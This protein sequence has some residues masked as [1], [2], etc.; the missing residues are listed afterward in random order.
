[1]LLVSSQPVLEF[2]VKN[3]DQ[4]GTNGSVDIGQV[5]LEETT[6]TFLSV[7]LFEAIDSAA[8]FFG[9]ST[10]LHHKSSS[11]GV[12]GVGQGFG[13]GDTELG[14]EELGEHVSLSLIFTE[15]PSLTGIV[16]T[17]VEG[18]V[19]EDTNKGDAQTSVNTLETVG[20]VGFGDTVDKT[21]VLFT[22][23]V[24]QS[25]SAVIEGVH[26]H[27]G[28]STSHTTSEQVTSEEF[29][30]LLFG[31]D[32]GDETSGIEILG[33]EVNGG[34]GEISDDVGQIT[35]PQRDGT[36]FSDAS[37]ET[38]TNTCVGSCLQFSDGVLT[39]HQKLDSFDGGTN[40]LGD[41]T[42]NTT[43]QQILHELVASLLLT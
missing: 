34:G 27:H 32:A 24:G 5:T 22:D 12:E 6:G 2:V 36:F 16:S 8:I 1:M 14:K 9:T 29:E 25:G 7:N 40:G 13:E 17:E 42:G 26:E 19:D 30:F 23:I 43:H 28:G 10:R 21:L 31:I 11:D 37:E 41:G 35:L 4:S 39:L 33:G 15:D 3:E 20:F 18:S 38:V